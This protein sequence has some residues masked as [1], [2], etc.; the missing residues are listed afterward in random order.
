MDSQGL[1]EAYAVDWQSTTVQTSGQSLSL[2]EHP[3]HIVGE[4]YYVTSYARLRRENCAPPE[5][6]YDYSAR[7][8]ETPRNEGSIDPRSISMLTWI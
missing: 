2:F 8:G 5:R 7:S 1:E 6:A 3:K 4:R